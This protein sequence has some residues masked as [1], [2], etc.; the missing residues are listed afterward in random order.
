MGKHTRGP[1]FAV[2][3]ER[4]NIGVVANS[5][6]YMLTVV[7]TDEYLTPDN[8]RLIAAAPEMFDMLHKAREAFARKLSGDYGAELLQDFCSDIDYLLNKVRGEWR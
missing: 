7:Q 2:E 5:G 4:G 1:W 8:A 6:A 3:D